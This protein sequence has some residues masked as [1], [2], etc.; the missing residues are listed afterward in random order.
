MEIRKPSM[1]VIVERGQHPPP[2]HWGLTEAGEEIQRNWSAGL[3]VISVFLLQRDPA[4][5]GYWMGWRGMDWRQGS[6]SGS[7]RHPDM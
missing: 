2:Q 3:Y 5:C 4:G 7:C 1:G 6:L